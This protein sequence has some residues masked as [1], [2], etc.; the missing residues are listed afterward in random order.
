[1][2]AHH[3]RAAP[4]DRRRRWRRLFTLYQH[5][6]QYTLINDGF[7]LDGFKHVFWLEW[8][9]R[10]WGRLIGVVF[11]GPMLWFAVTG[12]LERRLWP[13]LAAFFVFGGLQG[14][15]G[16]FMVASG[17]EPGAAIGGSPCAWCST[18]CSALLLYGA[19]LWTALDLAAARSSHRGRVSPPSEIILSW[20]TLAFITLTI[21]AGGLVAG[22]HAGLTYNTFPLMDGRLVPD[23]YADLQPFVRNLVANIPAVQFNH[24]L[25]A[26]LHFIDRHRPDDRRVAVSRPPRLASGPGRRRAACIQ[27]GFGVATLLLVVPPGLAIL[28]QLCATVLLTGVLILARAVRGGRRDSRHGQ[29]VRGT[30][31]YGSV[32][33]SG[34]AQG[35]ED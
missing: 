7:G 19:I 35:N 18:S 32:T 27:Y 21:A 26:D 3:G 14:A 11:L 9:H 23:G 6:P 10:L 13:R 8:T 20:A 24:R 30:P 2:G 16:W 22:L 25:L 5:I 29:I 31:F 28:H 34:A 33:P 1:M 15:V 4:D 12:R 17:F